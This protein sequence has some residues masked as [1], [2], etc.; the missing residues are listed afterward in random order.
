MKPHLDFAQTTPGC[1]D[2]TGYQKG[3][4][5]TVDF[6]RFT[7]GLSCI[8][9]LEDKAVPHG[10]V[11]IANAMGYRLT[12]RQPPPIQFFSDKFLFFLRSSIAANAYQTW[13]DT[14]VEEPASLPPER[15]R[16]FVTGTEIKEV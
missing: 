5:E 13:A 6:A 7:Y 3:W 10:G 15:F 4:A 8:T 11:D 1:H 12:F 2:G 9:L 14:T 16:F